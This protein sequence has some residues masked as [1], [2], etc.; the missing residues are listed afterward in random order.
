[1]SPTIAFG[2]LFGILNRTH[3]NTT[4][5]PPGDRILGDGGLTRAEVLTGRRP[6]GVFGGIV[7]RLL[8]I[9]PAPVADRRPHRF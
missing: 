7:R 3:T 2:T 5:R 6:M 9:L 8:G 1:M 4:G